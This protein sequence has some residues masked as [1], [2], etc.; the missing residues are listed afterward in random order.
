MTYPD[1]PLEFIVRTDDDG[2]RAQLVRAAVRE[3]V[4]AV[5]DVM[6]LAADDGLRVLGRTEDELRRAV[7]KLRGA[8][9]DAVIDEGPLV[10]YV[11]GA[12]RL[13]PFMRVVVHAPTRDLALLRADLDRRGARV[14]RLEHHIGS[15]VLEGEAPLAR[16]LGYADWVAACTGGAAR[17]RMWL[18]RYRLAEDGSSSGVEED[19][20][21]LVAATA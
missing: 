9:G 10:R 1:F 18:S 13:E 11:D 16:L 5:D 15:I 3:E 17:V 14:V 12:R 7:G 6:C 8:A 21:P 4:D 19:A 2:L 20:P